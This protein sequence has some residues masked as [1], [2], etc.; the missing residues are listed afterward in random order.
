MSWAALSSES[1]LIIIFLTTIEAITVDL[2]Q[3]KEE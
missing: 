2:S 3:I 1:S